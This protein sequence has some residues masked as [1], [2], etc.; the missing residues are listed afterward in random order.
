MGKSNAREKIFHHPHMRLLKAPGAYHTLSM[1]EPVAP[2]VVIL[3]YSAVGLLILLIGMVLGIFRRLTRIER[4][5]A[6]RANPQEAAASAQALK[7]TSIGGAFET[8]LNEDPARR[9]LPKGEQ[10]A[11]YRRWRQDHGLNWSNS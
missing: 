8:F 3:L 10:F 9:L 4:R 2:T 11:A 6:E 1:P 5:M 7:E